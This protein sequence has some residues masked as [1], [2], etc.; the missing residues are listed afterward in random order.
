MVDSLRFHEICVGYY[1]DDVEV[2]VFAGAGGDYQS[3][4]HEVCVWS[5]DGAKAV[6]VLVAGAVGGCC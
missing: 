4:F 6:V 1:E 2:V 3:R 5:D